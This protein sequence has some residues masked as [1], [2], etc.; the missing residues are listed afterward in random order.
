MPTSYTDRGR[1]PKTSVSKRNITNADGTRTEI[2][3]T[4]TTVGEETTKTVDTKHFPSHPKVRRE[5]VTLDDGTTGW[6][7]TSTVVYPGGKR[8]ITVEWPNG[9][10]EV[11]IEEP[12]ENTAEE[13]NNNDEPVEKKE[14]EPLAWDSLTK[15]LQENSQSLSNKI[16]VSFLQSTGDCGKSGWCWYLWR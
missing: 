11:K 6:K 13:T 9:E 3:T 8:E 7:K 12:A 5:G 14:K 2:T 15:C 1:K 4:T 16:A 10:K